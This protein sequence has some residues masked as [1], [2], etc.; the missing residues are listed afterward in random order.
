MLRGTLYL[1]IV[2]PVQLRIEGGGSLTH[3]RPKQNRRPGDDAQTPAGEDRWDMRVRDS[4]QIG[5]GFLVLG[6][7]FAMFGSP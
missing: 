4:A 3:R 1:L 6:A 7:G 5:G 2:F